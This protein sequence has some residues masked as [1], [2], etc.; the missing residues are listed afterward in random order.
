MALQRAEVELKQKLSR[1]EFL[2]DEE[3]FPEG[4]HGKELSFEEAQQIKG[5]YEGYSLRAQ[6]FEHLRFPA[7]PIKRPHPVPTE[8]RRITKTSELPDDPT[9]NVQRIEADFRSRRRSILAESLPLT[10]GPAAVWPSD[11][12][13]YIKMRSQLNQSSSSP[14]LHKRGL[15][16]EEEGRRFRLLFT[17]DE[18][19]Y[20]SA[21]E[22][23]ENEDEDVL[24]KKILRARGVNKVVAEQKGKFPALRALTGLGTH[25]KDELNRLERLLRSPLPKGPVLTPSARPLA[26]DDADYLASQLPV[27]TG[28][29]GGWLPGLTFQ[30]VVE[31]RHLQLYFDACRFLRIAPTPPY[32]FLK[33]KVEDLDLRYQRVIDA[34]LAAIARGLMGLENRKVTSINISH[35]PITDSGLSM[36]LRGLPYHILGHLQHLNLSHTMINGRAFALLAEL[37]HN[38]QLP[39]LKEIMLA[40]CHIL[41]QARTAIMDAIRHHQKFEKVSLAFTKIGTVSQR[42]CQEVAQMIDECSDLLWLD[43]SGNFFRKEGMKYLCTTLTNTLLE[44]LYFAQNGA[45]QE[46]SAS[47]AYNPGGEVV[48]GGKGESPYFNEFNPMLIFLSVLPQYRN[49]IY[50]DLSCNGMG[51]LAALVLEEALVA[52]QSLKKLN[53]RENPFGIA[54]WRALV[55]AL[56]VAGTTLT[57]LNCALTHNERPHAPDVNKIVNLIHQ[58]DQPTVPFTT[59]LDTDNPA[60]RTLMCRLVAF[61]ET[62]PP[63]G[64]GLKLTQCIKEVQAGGRGFRLT[65][66]LQDK[67]LPPPNRNPL[68]FSVFIPGIMEDPNA[69][70][71][72]PQPPTPA[73]TAAPPANASAPSENGDSPEGAGS[74]GGSG[75]KAKFWALEPQWLRDKRLRRGPGRRAKGSSIKEEGLVVIAEALKTCEADR[76]RVCIVEAVADEL[77]LSVDQSKVLWGALPSRLQKDSLRELNYRAK[78]K[79]SPRS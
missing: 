8:E 5:L 71:K 35:N 74:T 53:V 3:Q 10:N 40:G 38:R 77:E 56:C 58:S 50:L 4:I 21:L 28:K 19:A 48:S 63:T 41:P 51:S 15:D 16:P 42:R 76:T 69:P 7:V 36:L 6:Y 62:P 2:Q 79:D 24:E 22:E 66:G 59:R 55:R 31:S 45:S 9:E 14:V 72:P 27:Y 43:I 64:L 70:P 54:G 44:T 39:K 17:P 61:I 25:S 49:I 30:D 13:P 18:K 26:I 60:H 78:G 1:M 34:D 20:A 23:E 29:R 52:H 11:M 32:L 68:S 67:D 57:D 37:L 46:G 65:S 75:G 12:K 33:E 73:P 47:I